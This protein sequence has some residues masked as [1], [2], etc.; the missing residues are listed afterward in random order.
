LIKAVGPD[1]KKLTS[2]TGAN[3]WRHKDGKVETH[4]SFNKITGKVDSR[5][6]DGEGTLVRYNGTHLSNNNSQYQI[7]IA[8][9]LSDNETVRNA[10]NALTRKHP[11]NSYIAK[12]DDNGNF[13]L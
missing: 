7:N 8:L 4:Y 11:G 3:P 6:Y 13:Q 2:S 12:I 9:Q 5:V 1:G 10:T